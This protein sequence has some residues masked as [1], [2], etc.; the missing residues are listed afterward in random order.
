MYLYLPQWKF[1]YDSYLAWSASVVLNIDKVFLLFHI[2]VKQT[3]SIF[4]GDIF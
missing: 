3:L 4:V 1:F 2:Y